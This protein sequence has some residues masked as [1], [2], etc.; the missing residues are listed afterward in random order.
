MNMRKLKLIAAVIVRCALIV[1]PGA[2][3][4]W[5]LWGKVAAM[6]AALAS[7][8]LEMLWLIALSLVM[9]LVEAWRNRHRLA[10]TEP[11]DE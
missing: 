6:V 5:W 10:G 7:V 11:D 3:Y 8:G 1:A 4:A 9:V 2:A